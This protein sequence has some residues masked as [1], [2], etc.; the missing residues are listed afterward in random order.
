MNHLNKNEVNKLK[1]INRKT[2]PKVKG[3]KP[4][5]K[6]NH[7]VTPNYWNTTQNE[8]QID[9]EKPGKGYKHFLKK[10]DILK[11]IEIIPNWEIYSKGLDAIVL[12]SGESGHDGVYYY[13][14]VICISAWPKEMDMEFSKAYYNDHKELFKR[15]GVKSKE[16]NDFYFCEFN[17]DQIK[18]YQLL[19]IL[20]HEL[21]HHYDRM[22]TK[23]KHSTARGEK[24]AEDFAFENE[25]IMWNKYEETFNVVF[26]KE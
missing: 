12:E 14:G 1:R 26:Y 20:L 22:K 8:V 16:Q 21:G 24:F 2:T 10:R 23:S 4:L 7:E 18:A 19:H 3:G 6:N 11:F 17:E 13:V 25:D 9:S 5:R 15:L